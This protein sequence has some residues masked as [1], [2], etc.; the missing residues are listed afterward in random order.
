[1]LEV[2]QERV[3]GVRHAS[4]RL[5]AAGV[6]RHRDHGVSSSLTAQFIAIFTSCG[7]R[8]VATPRK[9]AAGAQAR[10]SAARCQT[11]R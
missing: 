11:R 9:T 3:G 10:R 4:H 1:M 5:E 7:I 2:Q 8:F 6:P